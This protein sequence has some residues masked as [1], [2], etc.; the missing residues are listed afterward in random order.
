MV[1]ELATEKAELLDEADK[2]H[3]DVLQPFLNLFDEGWLCDQRGVKAYASKSIF[4]LTTNVGQRMMAEM[5]EQG[6]SPDEIRE[7]MKEVLAQ[8][9]HTKAERPVFSPEFLSR[10][11]RIIVF[12]P[13][14]REAMRGIA[15][16]R[17][18]PDQR[19]GSRIYT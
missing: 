7:R 15:L 1:L 14:G 2:A 13:L 8:I 16:A 12:N 11:K 10:L 18:R 9:K 5:V 17:P 6:K 4:I 3:P 19:S